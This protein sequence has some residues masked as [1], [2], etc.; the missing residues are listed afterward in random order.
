VHGAVSQL[1]RETDWDELDY[2]VVDLPPGTGDA[3][4]TLIQSVPLAGV[5]FVSTPQ[6]VS[7]ADGIEGIEMFRKLKV[8]LLGLVE[9]MSGFEC[10]NCQHVTDIFSKGGGEKEA[11]RLEVPFLGAIPIDPQVVQAGDT[12]KPIVKLNPD[13]PVAKALMNLAEQVA[14]NV[15]VAQFNAEEPVP[16]K[17]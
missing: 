14:A 10:P 12:G 5:V 8:P 9:N 15:S 17:P 7:L 3:Q 6:A 2:L 13:S 1:L 11:K 16:T 4:L